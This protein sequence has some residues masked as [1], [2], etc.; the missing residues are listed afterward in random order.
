MAR[1]RDSGTGALYK[2]HGPGVWI[3][4]WYRSMQ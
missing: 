1:Q 2:R 4:K 3:A